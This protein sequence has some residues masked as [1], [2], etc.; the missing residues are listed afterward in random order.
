MFLILFVDGYE[1]VY[2]FDVCYEYGDIVGLLC[3]L[4]EFGIEFC[5]L[6]M[7]ESLL[8]EIFVDLVYNGILG[9]MDIL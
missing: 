3:C 7:W 5:D 6:C 4:G 2:S 9:G 8:E 1:L